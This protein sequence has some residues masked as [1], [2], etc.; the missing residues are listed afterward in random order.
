[1][2]E[3][4]DQPQDEAALEAAADET[5]AEGQVDSEDAQMADTVD[6]RASELIGSGPPS[7][8]PEGTTGD[9]IGEAEQHIASLDM[10]EERKKVRELSD[11]L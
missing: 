11:K 4:D 7:P 3:R 1:M 10:D 6:E 5:T 2:S 9:P 8:Q